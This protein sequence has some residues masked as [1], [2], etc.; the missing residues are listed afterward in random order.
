MGKNNRH[1]KLLKSERAK[2]KLKGK[3]LPKGT[4]VTNT[5]FKVRKIIIGEQLKNV[6]VN[7]VD[8]ATQIKDCLSKLRHHNHKICMGSLNNLKCILTKYSVDIIDNQFSPILKK[9]I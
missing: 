2:V 6:G 7:K 1:K 4:N 8:I 5:T 9:F 3:T